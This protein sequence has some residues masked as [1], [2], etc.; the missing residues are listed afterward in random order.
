MLSSSVQA[1]YIPENKSSDLELWTS[2]SGHRNRDPREKIQT[3]QNKCL[4]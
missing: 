4:R 2:D 3:V 1:T